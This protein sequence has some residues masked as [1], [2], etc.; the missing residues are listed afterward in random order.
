MSKHTLRDAKVGAEFIIT[1][2][3]GPYAMCKAKIRARI[4]GEVF[5]RVT[6]V[7]ARAMGDHNY[8]GQAQDM[9][10]RVMS[11]MIKRGLARF[12]CYIDENGM[13]VPNRYQEEGA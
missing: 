10:A 1:M 3:Y 13:W 5:Y 6:E 9:P 12:D 2:G 8:V 7:P 4:N 11:E